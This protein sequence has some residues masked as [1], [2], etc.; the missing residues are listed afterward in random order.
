MMIVMIMIM[1]MIIIIIIDDVIIMIIVASWNRYPNQDPNF[2]NN[3]PRSC[4]KP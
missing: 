3:P 4:S 1:I 2:E